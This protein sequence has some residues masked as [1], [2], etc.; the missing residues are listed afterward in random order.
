MS[1]NILNR[2][3]S[4]SSTEARDQGLAFY[5][6]GEI[7]S[8]SSLETKGLGNGNTVW[9]GGMIVINT[10]KQTVRNISTYGLSAD[11]PRTRGLLQYIIGIGPNG[12][13]VQ[14]GGIQKPLGTSSN[15]DPVGDL[16]SKILAV[17]QARV[18]KLILEA[19]SDG[20]D[21]CFRCFLPI[22]GQYAQWDMVQ[23]AGNW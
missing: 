15:I 7:D 10:N 21:R 16:V 11:Q 13:L 6:N 19:D 1:Q 20:S 8:G 12:V 3:S 17:M 9:L 14:L 23:A 5:L 2:P 4:G 22:S 18:W